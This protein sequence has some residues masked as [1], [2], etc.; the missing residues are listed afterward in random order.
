M[1]RKVHSQQLQHIFK[2]L[3]DHRDIVRTNQ[4]KK[5]NLHYVRR[6]ERSK[7]CNRISPGMEPNM[8]RLKGF[9]P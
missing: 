2:A 6:D 9:H 7:E 8:R 1:F 4:E 5:I 3:D